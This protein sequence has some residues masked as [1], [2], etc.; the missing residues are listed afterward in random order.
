MDESI[1]Q[2]IEGQVSKRNMNERVSD[3]VKYSTGD[4]YSNFSIGEIFDD[5]A[6]KAKELARKAKEEAKRAAKKAREAAERAKKEA[7]KKA[8]E[9]AEKAQDLAKKAAEEA[10]RAA[11]KANDE[12][13]KANKNIKKKVV[14]LKNKI[15]Q[16]GKNFRNKFRAILRKQILKKIENNIHGVAVR[17]FPA[18]AS[19]STL[20][21]SKFKKS[22][23]S[24]SKGIY[25]Q[26][27]KKWIQV[28]GN[29]AELKSAI[30]KGKSK[31][32]FLKLP[33]NSI[34]GNNYNTFYNHFYS[35]DAEESY[36]YETT[37]E[38]TEEVPSDEEQ[39]KGLKGFFAWLMS[40][41]KRN[42][43]EENPYEEG[44]ADGEEFSE[45][46]MVDAGNVPP[47]GEANNEVLKELLDTA[48]A[49]DAGG[50]TDLSKDDDKSDDKILGM[51]K[52]AFWIGTGVLSLGI[53]ALTV[54]LIKK[55]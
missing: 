27:V 43:S 40:V 45:D 33:Y 52:T 24:K 16:I 22:Y 6:K 10:K 37:E 48:D 4:D 38:T 46:M 55:K 28:G 51:P 8:K 49:D 34:E 9:A 26:L 50:D 17:L 13:K 53:I 32:R 44:S 23:I 3:R 47:E 54:Y 12:A 41:F 35:A 20:D 42:K 29:E 21:N 25:A 14:S 11:Q 19:K 30:L 1:L 31:K 7:T 15:G 18:I 36:E 2:T 5:A 39:S